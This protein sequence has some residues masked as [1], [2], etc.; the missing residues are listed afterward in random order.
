MVGEPVADERKSAVEQLATV[1]PMVGSAFAVVVALVT[2][3]VRLGYISEN[4][5]RI[6]K[7]QLALSERMDSRMGDRFT[8]KDHDNYHVAT[9]EPIKERLRLLEISQAEN[10]NGSEKK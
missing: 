1:W 3:Y 10:G 4:L 8:G 9:I 6:E 7:Q 5:A 2:M